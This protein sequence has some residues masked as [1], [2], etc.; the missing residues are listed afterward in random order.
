MKYNIAEL[1]RRIIEEPREFVAECEQRYQSYIEKAANQIIGNLKKSPIVLLSGPSGSGKTTSAF[2]LEHELEKNGIISHTIS[3]DD[4]F[5]DVDI[6]C[7]PRTP[8]GEIDF[9]HPECVDME[10]LN[11]HFCALSNGEEI[12]IPKFLFARQKRSASMFRRLKLRENEIAIF[13]GIHALNDA[14]TAPNPD[15]EKI[16]ISAIIDYIDDSGETCFSGTWLRLMRRVVRDNSFRGSSASYTIALWG[17]VLRGETLYIDPYKD[18]ANITINS[19]LPYEVAVMKQ[20]ACPLFTDLPE[21]NPQKEELSQ[22]LPALEKFS[23]LAPEFVP[24]DSLL[25]E[26]IGGSIYYNQ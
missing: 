12:C 1:N 22:I 14:V 2:K 26:F 24:D 19:A 7:A 21:D 4:Y 20:F 6:R 25:R 9:E 23:D 18:R 13:E 8:E 15:A 16:Y 11:E 3:I 17:N 10:L 5:H